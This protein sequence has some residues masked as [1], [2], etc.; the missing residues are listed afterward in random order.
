M[1]IYNSRELPC[2]LTLVL[3]DPR[4][5]SDYNDTVVTHHT[6]SFQVLVGLPLHVETHS[7]DVCTCCAS[8]VGAK[9]DCGWSVK[10]HGCLAGAYHLGVTADVGLV[11]YMF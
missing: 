9:L 11:V 7:G 1:S 2:H 6:S 8:E 3:F 10:M 5:F 4:G